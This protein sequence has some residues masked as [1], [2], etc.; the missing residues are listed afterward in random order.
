MYP[1]KEEISVKRLTPGH[2]GLLN[3]T[4]GCESPSTQVLRQ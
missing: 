2:D 4:V 1:S 3:F